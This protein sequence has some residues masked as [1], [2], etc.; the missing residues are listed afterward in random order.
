MEK[1]FDGSPVHASQRDNKYGRIY[2]FDPNKYSKLKKNK[3][4]KA[5]S[6]ASAKKVKKTATILNRKGK[7]LMAGGC[8]YTKTPPPGQL[9]PEDTSDLVN[10]DLK[11]GAG[12]RILK[13][14]SLV[15]NPSVA[16]KGKKI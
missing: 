1:T 5:W 4:K 8:D 11:K 2:V 9:L 15:D 7:L 10:Y 12:K 3:K 16:V 6:R 13:F 14:G